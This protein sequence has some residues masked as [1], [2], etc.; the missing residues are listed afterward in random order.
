VH[1]HTVHREFVASFAKSAADAVAVRV[2]DGPR[3][4]YAVAKALRDGDGAR[5]TL[6]PGTAGTQESVATATLRVRIQGPGYI[7]GVV[8]GCDLQGKLAVT[9]S[10]GH[11]HGGRGGRICGLRSW[12]RAGCKSRRSGIR[13]SGRHR[14][15]ERL[16]TIEKGW[17]VRHSSAKPVDVFFV[18]DAR[19]VGGRGEEALAQEL[20]LR[21][22][23]E[24]L[25]ER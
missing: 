10:A 19:D 4:S 24:R 14:R 22:K 13:G 9:D 20:Q 23:V 17:H 2:L 16:H 7:V 1:D 12:D 25:A 5:S 6:T 3:V 15:H 18:V 11:R 8:I 21:V